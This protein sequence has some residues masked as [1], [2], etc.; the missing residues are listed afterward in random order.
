MWYQA[1]RGLQDN[2]FG[3]A[4]HAVDADENRLYYFVEV[5]SDRNDD[6]NLD[7]TAVNEKNMFFFSIRDQIAN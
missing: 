2:V 5:A 6:L 1:R 7:L 3:E 4:T